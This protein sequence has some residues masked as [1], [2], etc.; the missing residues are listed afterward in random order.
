VYNSLQF[1]GKAIRGRQMVEA[2]NAAGLD[3]AIFGNHEFDI[4]EAELQERLNESHFQWISTNSFHKKGTG[5]DTLCPSRR[6]SFSRDFSYG[7]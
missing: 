1:N 7:K 6:T 5:T 4:R 3:F 2:L